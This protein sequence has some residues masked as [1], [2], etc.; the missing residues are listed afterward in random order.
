MCPTGGR[1]DKAGYDQGTL[2]IYMCIR[3]SKNTLLE[4]LKTLAI[5]AANEGQQALTTQP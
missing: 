4:A 3:L 1:K 2:C 5:I